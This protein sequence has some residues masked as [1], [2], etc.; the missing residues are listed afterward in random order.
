MTVG[1]LEK[2]FLLSLL[3]VLCHRQFIQLSS[4]QSVRVWFLKFVYQLLAPETRAVIKP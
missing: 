3:L 2:Q 1:T 4:E